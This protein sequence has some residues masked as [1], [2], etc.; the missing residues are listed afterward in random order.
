MI[1]TPEF[2]LIMRCS[3]YEFPFADFLIV[4]ATTAVNG[5]TAFTTFL[6]FEF[7]NS[8]EIKS[9]IPS[10][11]TAVNV[12]KHVAVSMKGNAYNHS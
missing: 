8:Q 10:H 4:N 12:S 3:D 2:V 9:Q 5:S 6:K 7:H 1:K 11:C